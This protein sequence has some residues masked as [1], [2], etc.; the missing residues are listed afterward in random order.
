MAGRDRDLERGDAVAFFCGD[1]ISFFTGVGEAT[2]LEAEG[3]GA[4]AVAGPPPKN[5]LA[6]PVTCETWNNYM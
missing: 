1:A 5:A 2:F 3:A 6:P 4:S